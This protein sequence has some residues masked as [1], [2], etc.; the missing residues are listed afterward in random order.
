MISYLTTGSILFSLYS[1]ISGRSLKKSFQ[2]DLN[3]IIGRNFKDVEMIEKTN[4][5]EFY[6]FVNANAGVII[7]SA[8]EENLKKCLSCS[9]LLT[10]AWLLP[11]IFGILNY[12]FGDTSYKLYSSIVALLVSFINFKSGL[13]S[14][15]ATQD[16][17]QNIIRAAM[18]YKSNYPNDETVKDLTNNDPIMGQWQSELAI[19]KMNYW[20]DRITSIAQL[21]KLGFH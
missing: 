16:K 17:N 14:Y 10:A 9:A 11:L 1:F 3:N 20:L 2:K 6:N 15:F 12:F 8:C 21:D 5:K 7:G 18:N 19:K 13:D 4:P